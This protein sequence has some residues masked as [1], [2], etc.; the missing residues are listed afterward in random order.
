MDATYNPHGAHQPVTKRLIDSSGGDFYPTPPWATFALLD[1]ED[2]SGE[3]WECACGDGTMSD[4]ISD[5]GL[6]V[7]SSDR[8]DHGFG[9]T[10]HDFLTSTRRA[11][12]I[13]TNPPYYD[14][15]NFVA[16]GLKQARRKLAL[17]LRL[18]F[19]EG[20]HR[21]RTIFHRH[22]PSTVWV[23]SE[24]ITFYPKEAERKGSGTTAYAWFVWN[25]EHRGSTE[26]CWLAP[27][28][29]RSY[30]RSISRPSSVIRNAP[31]LMYSR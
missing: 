30:R 13:I 28:Y 5:F 10:G 4:V 21:T 25:L 15:G 19:L 1:N 2:F 22:P 17:L 23:F 11:S 31:P 7:I 8:F 9:E 29:K 3:V 6:P 12:N 20:Q 26:L 27:G 24:R 18:A 16:H 14:A